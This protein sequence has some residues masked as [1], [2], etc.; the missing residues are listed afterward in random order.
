MPS[1]EE[2]KRQISDIRQQLAIS[3]KRISELER[4]KDFQIVNLDPSDF[5]IEGRYR[6][7]SRNVHFLCDMTNGAFTV[8]LPDVGSVKDVIFRFKKTDTSANQ[9]TVQ[10]REGQF[11]NKQNTQSVEGEGANMPIASNGIGWDIL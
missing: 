2:T 5:I 10:A 7:T 3:N 4:I 11:I 6:K 1:S 8:L 9:L